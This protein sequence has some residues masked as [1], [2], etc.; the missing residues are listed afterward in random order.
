[1]I[2]RMV[3]KSSTTKILMFLSNAASQT[4]LRYVHI[5]G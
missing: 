4:M 1:M 3:E 5:A 2:R